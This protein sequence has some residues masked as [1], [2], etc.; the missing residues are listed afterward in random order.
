MLFRLG[1]ARMQL[2]IPTSEQ[3]QVGFS[4]ERRSAGGLT[5]SRSVKYERVEVEKTVGQIVGLRID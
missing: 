4:K 2:T 5:A 1:Y 3:V